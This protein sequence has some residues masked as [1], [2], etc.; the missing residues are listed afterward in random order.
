MAEKRSQSSD[1]SGATTHGID[2][3]PA[4]PIMTSDHLRPAGFN[5][6]VDSTS[7][8]TLGDRTDSEPEK[9]SAEQESEQ[10]TLICQQLGSREADS[11]TAVGAGESAKQGQSISVAPR[12]GSCDEEEKRDQSKEEPPLEIKQ[13][14]G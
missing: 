3:Q 14:E 5:N 2:S 12:Q 8:D 11:L 10:D 4:A 9:K 6:E 13:Q 1:R 7:P